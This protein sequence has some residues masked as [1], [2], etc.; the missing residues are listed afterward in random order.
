MTPPTARPHD[1]PAK[2]LATE[3]RRRRRRLVVTLGLPSLACYVAYLALMAFGKD[4]LRTGIPG[5]L[6]VGW[7]VA[8]VVL[9]LPW[10]VCALFARG[11]QRSLDGLRTREVVPAGAVVRR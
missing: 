10:T 2:R 9:A 11:A 5:G 3:L 4:F 7:L 8:A 6:S 1:D